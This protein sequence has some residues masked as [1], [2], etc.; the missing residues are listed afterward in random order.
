M[1]QKTTFKKMMYLDI[2]IRVFAIKIINLNSE[3]KMSTI[4]IIVS[5]I[6]GI[7]GNNRY[8]KIILIEQ[9]IIVIF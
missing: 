9:N 5:L 8:I 3:V 4:K 6:F 1:I 7:N 2:E